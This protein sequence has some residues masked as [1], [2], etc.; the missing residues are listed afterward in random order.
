MVL[1]DL[2]IAGSV[3]SEKILVS[4]RIASWIRTRDANQDDGMFLFYF[5]KL[6]CFTESSLI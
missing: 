3:T 1:R 5:L 4:R 6:F 2:T